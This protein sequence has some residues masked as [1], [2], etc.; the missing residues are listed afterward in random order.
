MRKNINTERYSNNLSLRIAQSGKI[1]IKDENISKHIYKC[2]LIYEYRYVYMP[3]NC[4]KHVLYK[5][6]QNIL[7]FAYIM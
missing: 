5:P 1:N 4:M 3:S 7:S 6:G 2:D